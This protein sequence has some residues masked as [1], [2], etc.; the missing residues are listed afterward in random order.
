MAVQ[1]GVAVVQS[2]ARPLPPYRRAR[3]DPVG[4][5][6]F[7]R[8]RAGPLQYG[9]SAHRYRTTNVSSVIG[10]FCS[11]TGQPLAPPSPAALSGVGPR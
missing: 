6:H 4:H 8:L 1:A 2:R 10:S 11:P 9:A 7:G 3:A 5:G